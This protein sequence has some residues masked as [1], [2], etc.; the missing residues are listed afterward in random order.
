[1]PLIFVATSLSDSVSYI[2]FLVSEL[3][4]DSPVEVPESKLRFFSIQ[5]NII[6]LPD[7]KAKL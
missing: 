6:C 4:I 3:R 7:F 1:M 5:K 2:T